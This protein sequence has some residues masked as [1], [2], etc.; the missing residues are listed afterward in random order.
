MNL[1]EDLVEELKG[2][3]LLEETVIE[4]SEW[5]TQAEFKA[6]EQQKLSQANSQ[7]ESSKANS[8]ITPPQASLTEL[9]TVISEN[10]P[11]DIETNLVLPQSEETSAK[12]ED[13]AE[14]QFQLSEPNNESEFYRRR[15]TEEVSALKIVEHILS[16]VEREHMKI[17]PKTYD[18]V[19]VSIALHDFLKITLCVLQHS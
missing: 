15:A 10:K 3:N 7:I 14:F 1:F 13:I 4:T 17:S 5:E 19:P 12:Y 18:D 16:G 11:S 2:E 9:N 8:N 6:I